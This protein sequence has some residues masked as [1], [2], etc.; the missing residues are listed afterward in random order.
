MN[1]LWVRI[2]WHPRSVLAGPITVGEKGY[3]LF[4]NEGRLSFLAT[5]ETAV[6]QPRPQTHDW[7]VIY[8]QRDDDV[9]AGQSTLV[10]GFPIFILV[11]A[12]IVFPLWWPRRHLRLR[13]ANRGLHSG[14]CPTCGYDL[15]ATPAR[16]PECG[17]SPEMRNAEC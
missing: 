8:I 5:W 15:R 9:L 14:L 2:A 3:I 7:P 17:T 6:S 12:C 4:V 16:C 10:I 11:F 1:V 13:A